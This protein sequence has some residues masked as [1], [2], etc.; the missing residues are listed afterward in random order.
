MQIIIMEH[1]PYQ[2]SSRTSTDEFRVYPDAKPP[3]GPALRGAMVGGSLGAGFGLVTLLLLFVF[4]RPFSV[5]GFPLFGE[6]TWSVLF[7]LLFFAVVL[8]VVFGMA[9]CA[10]GF[11]LGQVLQF[12]FPSMRKSFGTALDD[13]SNHASSIL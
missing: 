3:A 5:D 2:P 11:W 4:I 13:P 1:N 12:W 10:F 7:W 8:P 6:F 9:F